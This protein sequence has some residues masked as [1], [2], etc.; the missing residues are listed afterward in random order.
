MKHLISV[1]LSLLSISVSA[2]SVVKSPQEKC[3]EAHMRVWELTPW[4]EEGN[5]KKKYMEKSRNYKKYKF[6]YQKEYYEFYDR[7]LLNTK[8]KLRAEY[9]ADSWVRCMKK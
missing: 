3:V 8:K 1:V 4:K 2:N 6:L 5:K 9:E 7:K